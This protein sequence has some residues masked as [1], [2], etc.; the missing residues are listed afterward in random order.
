MENQHQE[1]Q[2]PKSARKGR[3]VVLTGLYSLLIVF[4]S[5]W[6]SAASYRENYVEVQFAETF[7]LV[8][9][10]LGGVLIGHLLLRTIL[11]AIFTLLGL[12][13]RT[14]VCFLNYESANEEYPL[15]T[16]IAISQL[17][18]RPISFIAV[19]TALLLFYNRFM[20]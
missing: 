19:N 3:H 20:I 16:V 18:A 17:I 2:Q 4:L 5:I 9:I 14:V 7:L 10:S 12:L 11:S 1:Q 8:G 13:G 15:D 6:T